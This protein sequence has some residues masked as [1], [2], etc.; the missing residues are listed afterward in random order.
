[1]PAPFGALL[2]RRTGVDPKPFRVMGLPIV[3]ELLSE[4]HCVY[5]LLYATEENVSTSAN[6]LR[7]SGTHCQQPPRLTMNR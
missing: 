2:V 5:L 7:Q 4:D 3:D 6:R 1:M